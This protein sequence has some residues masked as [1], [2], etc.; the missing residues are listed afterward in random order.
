MNALA[1]LELAAADKADYGSLT[2]VVVAG[3]SVVSAVAALGLAWRGRAKWEPA[4]EDLSRAPA[5]VS[6][7]ISA[8]ILVLLWVFFGKDGSRGILAVIA[9]V[10][11][12]IT[13]ISAIVYGVL[14]AVYVYDRL[15]SVQSDTS[16]TIKIIGGF[17]FTAQADKVREK[18]PGLTTQE[19]LKGAAYDPDRV[20]PRSSRALMKAAFTLSYVGL[21]MMGTTALAATAILLLRSA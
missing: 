5:Q 21:T 18:N 19:L 10:A 7:L 8:V 17:R 20:W 9:G 1:L 13:L 16:T 14:V 12:A 3:G 15:V 4:E 2:P 11:A 6:G